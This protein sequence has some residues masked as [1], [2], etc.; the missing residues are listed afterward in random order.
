MRGAPV[1][2]IISEYRDVDAVMKRRLF[3]GPPKVML[4][5]RSGIRS[6]PMRVPSGS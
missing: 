5:T 4:E 3:L 1:T 6:R 2:D